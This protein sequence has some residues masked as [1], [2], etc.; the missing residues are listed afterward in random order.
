MFEQVHDHA[1]TVTAA[2]SPDRTV[3]QVAVDSL[4]RTTD[5][6]GGR[7][8][9]CARTRGP[10]RKWPAPTGLSDWDAVTTW[11]SLGFGGPYLCCDSYCSHYRN[12]AARSSNAPDLAMGDAGFPTVSR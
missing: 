6:V 9:V 12:A 1:M 3:V 7:G 2:S 5:D 8:L 4:S 11:R 10:L